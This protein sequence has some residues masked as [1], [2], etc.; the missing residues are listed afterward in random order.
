MSPSGAEVAAGG[1]DT[2]AWPTGSE[3]LGPVDSLGGCWERE[4][5]GL[6]QGHGKG[7]W[8]RRKWEH[9][10]TPLKSP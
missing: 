7:G 5:L 10:V 8:E 2:V 9:E 6:R 1:A 3:T 4:E